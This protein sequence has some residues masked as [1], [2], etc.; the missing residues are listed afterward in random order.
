MRAG[1]EG[2]DLVEER[3]TTVAGHPAV[4]HTYRWTLRW[5]DDAPA[6]LVPGG[7]RDGYAIIASAPGAAVRRAAGTVRGR[8]ARLSPVE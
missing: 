1:L 4:R 7:G 2:V 8:A 6:R 5:A 3:E